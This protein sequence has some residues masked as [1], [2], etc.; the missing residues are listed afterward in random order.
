MNDVIIIGGGLA[1]LVNA[2]LLAD[3]GLDVVVVEKKRYPFHRVCG[4]YISNE[5][6]PFLRKIGADPEPC[7]PAHIDKLFLSSASGK[8]IQ[9]PLEA[10]G[11][12]ISRYTFDNYLYWLAI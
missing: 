11:F 5:V 9:L 2:I 8:A 4:E 7:K 1:G 3:A 6:L 12:G 10:G